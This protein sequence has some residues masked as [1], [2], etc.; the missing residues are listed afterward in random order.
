MSDP[1]TPT[2]PWAFW[3]LFFGFWLTF[4]V[5]FRGQPFNDPGAF[6]HIRV[7]T[8]IVDNQSFMRTDPFTWSNAGKFWIPQQWGA[9]CLMAIGYRVGGFDT[10]LTLMG[11]LLAGLAAWIGKRFLDAGLHVLPTAGLLAFG[12]ATAG[13]HFYLR[14]HLATIVLMAVFMG[15]L[16]DFDRDR[17]GFKKLLW[18]I[19]LCILWTNLHGGVLGGIATIGLAVAGWAITRRFPLPLLVRLTLLVV[20]CALGTLVN[21][22]FTGMHRTWWSI[23]DSPMMKEYVVEHQAL[24]LARSDGQAVVAF[25]IFYLIMLAG[26]LPKRPRVTWL[27]P[28]AWLALSV[29]SIRHGPLFCSVA[30]V[31]LAD[32]LP[33]TV[34][35]RLLRKYGDTFAMEP[36]E[37]RSIGWKGWS[38]PIIGVAIAICLQRAETPVPVI[39]Y[40][41]ARFDPKLVPIELIG[42]LHE[43]ALS[44]PEGHPI[45]N[46]ANLGGFLIFNAPRLK[47]FMDDRFE[48]YGEKWLEE[49]ID[50]VHN[51][52]ERIDEWAERGHFDRALVESDSVLDDYLKKP[53][54]KWREV[55]RTTKATLYELK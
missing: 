16:V 31:A 3:L 1:R 15:W 19:P 40:A 29:T 39:G 20:A 45:F 51:H 41:W 35:F 42:P 21:P 27:V 48:L 52:P 49:Y 50:M 17:I 55:K 23:V 32:F 12:L 7:G 14:P 30:L 46:D 37:P 34:W 26:T 10:L 28:L 4:L 47:I 33:E 25:G 9:E 2:K 36:R 18:L 38:L 54:S 5:L 22:F 11:A 44:K 53:E 13:F 43:Y 6:W 24:S 8:L